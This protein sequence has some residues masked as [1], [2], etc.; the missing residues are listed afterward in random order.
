MQVCAGPLSVLRLLFKWFELLN[1][2]DVL[3]FVHLKISAANSAD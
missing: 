1:L 3:K 2:L